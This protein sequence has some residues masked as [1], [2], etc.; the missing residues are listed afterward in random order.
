MD[1]TAVGCAFNSRLI[2]ERLNP[3]SLPSNNFMSWVSMDISSKA[4]QFSALKNDE[5]GDPC[6]HS[7]INGRGDRP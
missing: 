2:S 1:M 6:D 5:G 4:Q 7:L 3:L